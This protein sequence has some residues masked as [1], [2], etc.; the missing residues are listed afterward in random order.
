MVAPGTQSEAYLTA[1]STKSQSSDNDV[2]DSITLSFV[3][4]G[5]LTYSDWGSG[6]VTLSEGEFASFD[7]AILSLFDPDSPTSRVI[8]EIAGNSASWVTMEDMDPD[9]EN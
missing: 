8:A 4:T 5:M 6:P 1:T 2:S 7:G 3:V 9:F